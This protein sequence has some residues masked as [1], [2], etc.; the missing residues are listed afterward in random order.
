MIYF[1]TMIGNVYK[2]LASPQRQTKSMSGAD[3]PAVDLDQ[4]DL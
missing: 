2:I 3:L 4:Y 1:V